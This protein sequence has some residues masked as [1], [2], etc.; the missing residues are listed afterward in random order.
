MDS[1]TQ[2]ALGATVAGLV[3]GKR[4]SPKV[5]LAGA[6]LGTLPD[7]D[8]LI[9]YGDPVANTVNHR[10][11]SHSLF[12]LPW[13]G[14]LIAWCWWRWQRQWPLWQVMTLVI[15]VLVTHPL[16]DAMTVYGTKLF[17]PLEVPSVAVASL[18][19][20]DPLY[21]VPLLVAL[22]S[23]LVW[24]HLGAKACGVGLMV[25][26]LYLASSVY[27]LQQI[28]NRVAEQTQGTLLEGQPL[29]IMPTPFNTLLWRVVVSGEEQYWEGLASRLDANPS[30][31][32]VAQPLG[33][34]PLANSDTLSAL[35]TFSRNFIRFENRN[36][37]Q[38][39]TDLRFGVAAYQ[40]FQ[41]LLAEQNTDGDWYLVSPKQLEPG[42]LPETALPALWQR[43]LGDQSIDAK[44]CRQSCQQT[45]PRWA[46]PISSA[47]LPATASEKQ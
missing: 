10:G 36:G 21:T 15:A 40:P 32:W 23:A 28:K 35:R 13:V 41:F 5:L 8:V 17:W 34:W 38:V 26:S 46:E 42:P 12:V 20:I 43:L 33:E 6:A 45:D 14:A 18:F 22:I 11:F 7:L 27:Q 31:D 2:A 39:V 29:I 37:Q 30:I 47:A 44:L 25:S 16:L 1:V 3:A 19:I 4:C 24:R 9:D